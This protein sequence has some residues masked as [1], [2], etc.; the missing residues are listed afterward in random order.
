MEKK[1]TSFLCFLLTLVLVNSCSEETTANNDQIDA[2]ELQI[3][4]THQTFLLIK[5]S[6]PTAVLELF[7]D[8]EKLISEIKNVDEKNTLIPRLGL[9]GGDPICQGD[10]ISFVKCVKKALDE[11]GCVRIEACAYCAYE[12]EQK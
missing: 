6:S 1:A 9:P 12:C 2:L 4:E 10:G 7:M 11:L 8:G 5:E 3:Q